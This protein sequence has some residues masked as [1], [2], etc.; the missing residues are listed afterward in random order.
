MPQFKAF[1]SASDITSLA[2]MEHEI[3]EWM[4]H[5][6]PRIL[7]MAQSAADNAR[8]TVPHF[9]YVVVSFV[10]DHGDTASLGVATA[11]TAVPDVFDRN[12]D[13]AEL[14]PALDEDDV[15]LPEAELPY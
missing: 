4:K 8:T 5:E 9:L 14:D 13:D 12:L 10:Y 15:L 1:S 3:N 2:R 6:R 7:H 11:T